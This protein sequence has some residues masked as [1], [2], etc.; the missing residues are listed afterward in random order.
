MNGLDAPDHLTR[1]DDLHGVWADPNLVLGQTCGLPF[2]LDLHK[3]TSL[4]GTFNYHLDDTAPGYYRS[5]VVIRAGDP[6][7]VGEC[8]ADVIAVNSQDSQSGWGAL[9]T[10]AKGYGNI[11]WGRLVISGSHRRSAEMVANGKASLASLDLVSFHLV[12]RHAPDIAAA[13]E[14]VVTTSATPALPLICAPRFD[15]DQ[16]G[17]G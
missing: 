12:Q 7:S 4:I 15:P 14:V 11:Q 16:I 1:Q 10:W 2:S 6:R 13:L 3:K 5:V 17:S 9:A 8:F